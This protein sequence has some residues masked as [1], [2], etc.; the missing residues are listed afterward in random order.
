MIGRVGLLVWNTETW[1]PTTRAASPNGPTEVEVG[2]TLGRD[3]WG[4]G[5]ATEAAGAVRDFAL[6]EA[7]RR[8]ADRADHPRQHGLRE[9]RAQARARAR[10][11]HHA[12][13]PRGATVRDRR[14]SEIRDLLRRT[15]ELAADYVESLGER[16]VFP[17]R[18]AGAAARGARRAAARRS[19]RAAAGGRRAR[20]RGRAGRRRARQRA[21]LRLRDRRRRCRPRSP[22]T[23]SP[24]PGTRTPA[25]TSAG[26]RPRWSS[27]SRASGSSTCSGLPAESS[28]GFVTGTQ[29]AHVTGLAAARWHVLDAV[30]WD[31]GAKGLTG[32]PP[33]RVSPARSGT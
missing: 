2:Y 10:A 25:S 14:M 4:Q 26:R 31:V 23:G 5:F 1:E 27:R 11:Q 21:L 32:A 33:V 19:G 6:G 28:V 20:G 13:P 18:D 16:P 15:A 8:A 24:R 17:R 12:R 9:R 22:R 30:G 3:F 29:M 7:R